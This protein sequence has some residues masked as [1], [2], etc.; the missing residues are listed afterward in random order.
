MSLVG[1]V[2]QRGSCVCLLC[3][4]CDGGGHVCLLCVM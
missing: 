4:M 2:R 1:H 3:V